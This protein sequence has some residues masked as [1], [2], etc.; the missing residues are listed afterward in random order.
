MA[1]TNYQ[2]SQSGTL[3]EWNTQVMGLLNQGK[4]QAG[5]AAHHL[6]RL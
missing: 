6:H 4:T 5:Q 1:S 2:E 3:P